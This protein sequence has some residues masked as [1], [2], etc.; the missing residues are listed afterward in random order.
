MTRIDE[1]W[2]RGPSARYEEIAARFRPIFDRIGEA[3]IERD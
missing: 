3:A 1:G 2:G